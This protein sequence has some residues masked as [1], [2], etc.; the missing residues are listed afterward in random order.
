MKIFTKDVLG[1][2]W[3]FISFFISFTIFGLLVVII[4]NSGI[5]EEART[6]LLIEVMNNNEEVLDEVTSLL[7][8]G[9]DISVIKDKEGNLVI[10]E[11]GDLPMRLF[12]KYKGLPE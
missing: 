11:K 2:A 3:F 5:I 1:P 4:S 12:I 8:S 7:D 9:K 10:S 6:E